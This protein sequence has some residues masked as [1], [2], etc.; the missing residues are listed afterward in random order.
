MGKITPQHLERK[1]YV[2][3]RQSSLAQ[4][5]HHRESTERQYRLQERA[6]GL[7][8]PAEQVEVIDADQGQSGASSE[9]RPGFQRLVSEVA[10]GQ[11][12][13]VLGLEVSRLARC[14][15]DWYRL[16][17]VA[18]LTG[19]LIADE[20]GIYDPRHYNDR[21][22]LG[23]KGTLSEAELHLLKQRMIGGRR[24][25][26][27]RGEFR[28]RLPIGYV[29]EKGEGIR[30]DPDERVRDTL[31]LFFRCFDRIG[32][33][34]GLARSFEEHQQLFPYR[35]GWGS[36][37]VAVSWRPLSV[38]RAVGLLRNPLYAGV[39]VYNRKG[40]QEVDVEDPSAGGR[41]WIEDSHP[42]YITGEQYQENLARL[43]ANRQRYPWIRP[44]ASAREGKSLL[45]GMVLCGRCGARMQVS[46][47]PEGSAIYRC[48]SS[49]TRRLCQAVHGRHV[50]P[51]V[52]KV[53]L[54]TLTREELDLA[55]GA[56]EKLAERAHEL[57][58]QWE[59]R[60][61]AARYEADKAARRYYQ[62][63]PE[64]RLVART[65]EAEW[66]ER[67]EALERLQQEYARLR[68]KPPFQLAPWQREK[69]LALAED[70]PRLWKAPTTRQSQRKRLLRL[71]IEDITLQ[72]REDPWSVEV[73]IRWKTG[74]VSWHRA[75]RVRPYPHTTSSEVLTRIEALLAENTDQ[76]IT[77][78]LNREGHR[79]G[80]G[81]VFT[82]GSVAHIRTR[83]GLRK[84][85]SQ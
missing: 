34:L 37:E 29:W 21:L 51:L 81:R 22:L 23:L 41:I 78:I 1:A 62:V 53:L 45:Q 46:Y 74:T 55:L 26:A 7:G 75:E 82:A 32:S 5:E 25:K 77:E 50:D 8:W 76:E 84:S 3:V 80:Y 72:N 47:G 13:V 60:I 48:I 39:Y 67:L 9:G 52:E 49:G 6:Q 42:G 27:S 83:R 58:R 28:I 66:N 68:Q 12:G 11:V 65:L 71:L 70:L 10:L 40:A 2:Y 56:L 17:E 61:E 19:T 38:S 36:P 31:S 24:N 54:E 85:S 69:I 33:A 14:C 43:A 59:K 4:V 18:T 35:D 44:S 57:D 15:A 16:L 64:N 79:S 30:M 20:E 63:E 73:A